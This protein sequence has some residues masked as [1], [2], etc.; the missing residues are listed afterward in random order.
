MVQGLKISAVV[1]CAIFAVMTLITIGMQMK[2]HYRSVYED[3]VSTIEQ[4]KQRQVFEIKRD[5]R[6]ET[7]NKMV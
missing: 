1:F 5:F 4:Q 6:A 7:C 3:K 2:A